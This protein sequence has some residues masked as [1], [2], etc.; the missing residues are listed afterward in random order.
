MLLTNQW[1]DK[2]AASCVDFEARGMLTRGA[3]RIPGRNAEPSSIPGSAVVEED[4]DDEDTVPGPRV[5]AHVELAKT[6]AQRKV[7][8]AEL[9]R[10]INQPDLIQLIRSFLY[11]QLLP[12]PSSDSS[13]S[14]SSPP[15]HRLPFFDSSISVYTSALATFYAPSDLCGTGGMRR[16]RIRAIS[17]W[18]GGAGRYDCVFVETDPAAQGMLGLDVARVRLFF[19]FAFRGQF[20]PCALVHWFSRT[21]NRPD[22]D[23]GMWIV[24]PEFN[25]DGSHKAAVIH[26][27]TIRLFTKASFTYAIP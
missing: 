20:Y 10:K 18:R 11:E 3:I 27:D 6:I 4:D 24:R 13:S 7:N 17:S 9:A 25:T 21:D 1:L 26:L 22:D 16:E 15:R 12:H 19:S 14:G 23:T 5:L 8:A 2:L